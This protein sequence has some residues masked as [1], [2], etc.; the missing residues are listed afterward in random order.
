M[1]LEI[2]VNL[3]VQKGEK[4]MFRKLCITS[5]VLLIS[6][7]ILIG[8]SIAQEKVKI[9]VVIEQ[10]GAA[11]SLGDY[12]VKGVRLAVEE[13]NKAGGVLGR[14]IEY[15]IF[16]SQSKPPISVS[17]MKKAAQSLLH[18]RNDPQSNIANMVCKE[19]RPSVYRLGELKISMGNKYIFR[20][21]TQQGF[22]MPKLVSWVMAE[23]KPK[24]VAAIY[25]NNDYGIGG[26]ETVKKVL[27]EKWNTEIVYAG[28]TEQKQADFTAELNHLKRANADA[29]CAYLLEEEAAMFYRQVKK[30]GLNLV[31]F[32]PNSAISEDTCRLGKEAVDGIYGMSSF[33]YTSPDIN[34]KRLAKYYKDKYGTWP[35]NEFMKGYNS[36]Y[37]P[38]TGI[39]LTKS[40]DKEKVVE[41]LHGLMI[42]PE[43]QP[44]VAGGKLYYDEVGDL[45]TWDYLTKIVWDG[46][47]AVP[48][49]EAALP[50][51]KGPDAGKRIMYF[52]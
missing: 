44:M 48:Q 17:A 15:E 13:I 51:L 46:K 19:A 7:I 27:K 33:E 32:G 21:S 43:I 23:K 31:I 38:V 20:T 45:H 14:Q 52:K 41:K 36:I 40:F 18:L 34:C 4:N 22:E 2:F 16:D 6:I 25:V 50:P 12:F 5:A 30:M 24:R 26:L 47:A 1:S 35:D 11:A 29:L 37:V 42:T 9:A 49:V 8:P 10:T 3:L 28:A 39:Q